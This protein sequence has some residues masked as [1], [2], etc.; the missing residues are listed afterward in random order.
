MVASNVRVLQ[1]MLAARDE[2]IAELKSK[3]LVITA[4][5]RPPETVL[6]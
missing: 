6:H 5:L 2:E 4:A 1:A 3:L